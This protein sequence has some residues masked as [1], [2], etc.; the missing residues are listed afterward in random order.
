MLDGKG[1]EGSI[2]LGVRE[3]TVKVPATSLMSRTG[4]R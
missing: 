3:R 4:C 2:M 1:R